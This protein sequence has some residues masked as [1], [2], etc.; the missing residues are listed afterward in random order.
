MANDV[1]NVLRECDQM[2]S[3]FIDNMQFVKVD[4]SGAADIDAN[5]T[6]A[7]RDD[8]EAAA[9][10][11][12]TG[13]YT[14]DPL[15]ADANPVIKIDGAEGAYKGMRLQQ[16]VEGAS[17]QALNAKQTDKKIYQQVTQLARS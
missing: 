6:G 1:G 14:V 16:V 2:L 10:E 12:G 13:V 11:G 9:A 15:S 7:L 3:Q 5:V 4:D 8:F 17:G